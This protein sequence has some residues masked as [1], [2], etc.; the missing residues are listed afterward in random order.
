[1]AFFEATAVALPSDYKD[2]AGDLASAEE[3]NLLYGSI[4]H[5]RNAYKFHIHSSYR[6]SYLLKYYT[7][8]FPNHE[9]PGNR[10]Y[11]IAS[12]SPQGGIVH[13]RANHPP[14]KGDNTPVLKKTLPID[15]LYELFKASRGVDFLDKKKQNSEGDEDKEDTD[16]EKTSDEGQ[17]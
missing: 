1:L 13:F 6:K 16:T 7:L 17:V 11:I 4:P 5:K 10:V 8:S 15:D 3:L 12:T 2:E 14:F 9:S